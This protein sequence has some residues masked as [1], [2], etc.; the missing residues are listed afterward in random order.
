MQPRDIKFKISSAE[1]GAAFPVRVVPRASK[2]E[3][4]GR[5]GDAVKIRLTAP[6]VEG[7]ANEAL[8]DFLSEL[9]D[10]RKSQIEILTGHASRDKIVCVV[11]VSPQEV[12]ARLDEFLPRREQE[13][14]AG[15]EEG[16]SAESGEE[17]GSEEEV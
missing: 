17:A 13:A 2:N 7:A 16:L 9:L 15:G 3:V 11:G 1:G 8:V 14:P 4:S 12:E 5:H 10:V 6:P